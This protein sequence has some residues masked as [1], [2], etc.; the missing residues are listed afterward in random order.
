MSITGNFIIN[1]ANNKPIIIDAFF[2]T[3]EGNQPIAIFCHG[4]KGFKDWGAWNIM[5]VQFAA[6]GICFV[7]F[8][9][10]HN[11]GTVEQPIDFPDLESFGNNNYSKELEDLGHVI[12][13]CEHNF[14]NNSNIN[15]NNIALIGHSRGAGIAI[16]TASENQRIKKLI[17]LAGVSDFKSRFGSIGE[18]RQWRADGIKFIENGRTKQKMPHYYQFYEDYLANEQR[19]NIENALKY[20][21]IP[22]L[23]IHGEADSTVKI[24]EAENLAKWSKYSNFIRVKGAD[25]VFNTCHPWKSSQVSKALN[26]VITETTE[27]IFDK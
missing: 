22:H 3:K 18:I 13:W 2:S 25:H 10:S 11:G 20:L 17:T 9:F 8:N 12:A 26:K 16:I 4:Y 21:K 6:A 7:K 27:F 5:A 14:K 23:I 1:G 15:T 19:L 24:S